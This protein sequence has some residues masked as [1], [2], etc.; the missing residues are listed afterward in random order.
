MIVYYARWEA[1]VVKWQI[2]AAVSL[3]EI[4]VSFIQLDHVRIIKDLL[5]K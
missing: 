4:T 2:A 3:G 1:L 5:K